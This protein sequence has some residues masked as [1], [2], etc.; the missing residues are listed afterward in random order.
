MNAI[1]QML[2]PLL[3]SSVTGP[4]GGMA[5]GA[6]MKMLT[7]RGILPGLAK[8]L[9]TIGSTIGGFAPFVAPS[10]MGGGEGSAPSE[11][12]GQN[13]GNLNKLDAMMKSLQPAAD[14]AMMDDVDTAPMGDEELMRQLGML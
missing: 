9:P 8:A 3:I 13:E 1:L 10:L 4:A 14:P 12:I 2:L 11:Q 6:L 5:G 7:A